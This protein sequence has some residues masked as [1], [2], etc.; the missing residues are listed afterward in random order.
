[1]NFEH[2]KYLNK[3]V[4]IVE[5]EQVF[6]CCIVTLTPSLFNLLTTSVDHH[7]E[8]SQLICIK[9]IDWFLYDGQHWSLMVSI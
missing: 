5:F 7:I 3:I 6:K 1:M 4:F 2:I 8:T 9:S